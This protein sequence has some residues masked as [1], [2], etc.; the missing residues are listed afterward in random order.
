WT[1]MDALERY[2]GLTWFRLGDRDLATHLYRTQRLHDGATLTEV[3]AEVAAAW[4]VAARLLPMTDDGVETRLVVAGEGEVGFQDY[5][6]R[7][8]HAVPVTGVRYAGAEEARP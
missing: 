6:V 2:G 5:F 8:H 3:A 7:Y 4:G 1:V